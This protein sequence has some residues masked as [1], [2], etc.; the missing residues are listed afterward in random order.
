MGK[1]ARAYSAY[2]AY[3]AYQTLRRKSWIRDYCI[4]VK[5]YWP[6]RCQVVMTPMCMVVMV[7][8]CALRKIRNPSFWSTAR[9]A[10]DRPIRSIRSVRFGKIR[11]PS[12]SST[13]RA[14]HD[15]PIRSIRRV[16]FGKICNP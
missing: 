15:M 4:A 1:G 7:P 12:F 3:G 16:R 6:K 10:H 8:V 13:A 2:S 9:A 14:A 5:S 11:N